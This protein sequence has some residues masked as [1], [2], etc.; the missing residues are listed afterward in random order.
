[1]S[2]GQACSNN[3]KVIDEGSH[4][5]LKHLLAEAGKFPSISAR[6]AR[7]FFEMRNFDELVAS[8]RNTNSGGRRVIIAIAGPPGAGKST[9]SERLKA[10]LSKEGAEIVPMDGFHYDN[11]ILDNM[12]WR[13][14]KGAPHTFDFD[15]LELVLRRVRHS[16]D[17]VAVPIFDRS[18]DLSRAGARMVEPGTRYII[19]EG[20][21]LLLDEAPW[22]SLA[23][24]FDFKISLAVPPDELDERLRR[25]WVE[26]GYSEDAVETKLAGNDRLNVEL[27]LEKSIPA[28]FVCYSESASPDQ[29]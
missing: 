6:P 14:R 21:Y 19:V 18:L 7:I 8:I 13:T 25:R 24:L 1:M 27:V 20:N 23:P 2:E 9:I 5:G 17:S 4:I 3:R 11:A 29:R 16:H 15:G 12:G 22:S 28:D 10:E 26:L